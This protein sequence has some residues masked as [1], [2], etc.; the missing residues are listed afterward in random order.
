MSD[1]GSAV[2]KG[3][4]RASA[5]AAKARCRVLAFTGLRPGEL[6]RYRPEHWNRTTQTLVVY[7]GKGG[8]TRTIPL[9]ASFR[10]S[11]LPA[12]CLLASARRRRSS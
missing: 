1:Q 7:T 11:G 8:R 3:K 5:S 4:P 12:G 2:V 6:M 10:P 9:S